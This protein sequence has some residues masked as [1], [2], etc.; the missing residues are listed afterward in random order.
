VIKFN[1]F[2]SSQIEKAA[3]QLKR[4]AEVRGWR[5]QPEAEE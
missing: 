2:P 5:Y 4:A 1:D 3:K